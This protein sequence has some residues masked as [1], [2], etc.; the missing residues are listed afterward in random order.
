MQASEPQI[1]GLHSRGAETPSACFSGASSFHGASEGEIATLIEIYGCTNGPCWRKRDG[2]FEKEHIGEWQGVVVENGRIVELSLGKR[3]M[4]G[5]LPDLAPLIWLRKL[6][7]MDK[8]LV[9]ALP[10][11]LAYL[12]RLESLRGSNNAF[13]GSIPGG[14]DLM[15]YPNVTYF[16]VQKNKLSGE[17]LC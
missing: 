17:A 16:H 4:S 3:G 5:S 8:R 1:G 7:V 13:S 14:S 11:S 12:P 15:A 9:G 10:A 2:W 6:N